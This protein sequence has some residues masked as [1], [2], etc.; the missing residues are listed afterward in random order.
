MNK[1]L[2]FESII[3]GCITLIIGNLITRLLINFNSYDENENLENLL[4][5]YCNS[6]IFHIMLFLTGVLLHLLLEYI[7]LEKWYCQK[8]CLKDKCKMVCIK[9]VTNTGLF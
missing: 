5:K 6:F 9:N 8:I 4:Y 7:G 1:K 2:I 3:I